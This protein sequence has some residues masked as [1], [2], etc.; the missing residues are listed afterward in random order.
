MRSVD[1]IVS[2]ETVD[3]R[4]ARVLCV[5]ADRRVL[6]L[7]WRDPV[8]GRSV[9]EPPG[10]GVNPDERPIEAARRELQ[11]ETGIPGDC[12]LDRRVAVRRDAVW[13]GRHYVG[14][15]EFFLARIVDARPLVR[16]GL[17]DEEAPILIEQ[18]WVHWSRIQELTDRV[19]PPCLLDILRRIDPS[20]PWN[21]RH[22]RP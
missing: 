10:G 11:E 12:V 2:V 7:R 5:D 21:V 8:D 15:E 6:L 16:D 4:A 3:R 19:E 13:A 18:A 1:R 14:E 22:A 20:G 17:S 9:W